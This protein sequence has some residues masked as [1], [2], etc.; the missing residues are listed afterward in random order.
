MR[1]TNAVVTLLL[2]VL[3][4]RAQ[5]LAPE[6]IRDPPVARFAGEISE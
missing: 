2:A 4:G 6:E 5:V 3:A 1:A